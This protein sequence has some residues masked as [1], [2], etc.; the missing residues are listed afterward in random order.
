MNPTIPD[1]TNYV[2]TMRTYNPRPQDGTLPKLVLDLALVEDLAPCE[3]WSTAQ[4][5]SAIE[6]IGGGDTCHLADAIRSSVLHSRDAIWLVAR[7]AAAHEPTLLGLIRLHVAR[8]AA[9]L[10]GDGPVEDRNLAAAVVRQVRWDM[11]FGTAAASQETVA[12]LDQQLGERISRHRPAEG[13][14]PY[15]L[16]RTLQLCLHQIGLDTEMAILAISESVEVRQHGRAGD[17]LTRWRRHLARVVDAYGRKMS[18]LSGSFEASLVEKARETKR[19]NAKG[20]HEISIDDVDPSERWQELA[21]ASFGHGKMGRKHLHAGVGRAD[22][23]V[24]IV[25]RSS[26]AQPNREDVYRGSDLA[27]AVDAYNEVG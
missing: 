19:R 27:A 5:Q 22:F 14:V 21:S 26:S 24:E 9:R 8:N 18:T 2:R 23:R 25:T 12:V 16:W 1:D 13:S 17:T 11:A 3:L 15:L 20:P 6:V 4:I 10:L 7:F